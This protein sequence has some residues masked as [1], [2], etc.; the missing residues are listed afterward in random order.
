MQIIFILI[1]LLFSSSVLASTLPSPWSS[2]VK[3]AF[4]T[5]YN[6]SS[7]LWFTVGHGILTEVY[8]PTVD[9]AQL[10]DQQFL[11]TDGKSFLFEER[12]NAHTQVEW[13]EKGV[14]AFRIINKDPEGRFQ[15]E[16]VIFTDPNRDSLIQKIKITKYVPG[17]QFFLLHNPSAQNTPLGN[18]GFASLHDFP[19]MGLF[20][21]Q[22]NQAQAVAASVPFRKVSA[23]FYG[24]TDGY[25]DLV[26]DFHMDFEYKNADHG[27]VVLMG[28]LQLPEEVGVDT[29]DLVL[30]FSSNLESAYKTAQA[31]LYSDTNFIL[32]KYKKE[33]QQYQN[34]ILNLEPFSLDGGNLFRASVALL[35]SME[36][37]THPGGIIASPTIPWGEHVEDW[38]AGF[39]QG[40]SRKDLKAGYHLIWPRDLY[41]MAT[42]FLAIEDT[43]TAKAALDFL[44]NTQ[45]Q[46]QAGDWEY[47]FRKHSKE[48]SWFQNTW[49]SGEPFWGG[50]QLDQVALPIVLAYRLWKADEV[51]ASSVW[52]MVKK[53]ADFIQAFGPWTPMERWEEA[54]GA[55]PSTI[56][57]ELAGL[58]K[59]SEF[60]QSVGDFERAKRYQATAQ[61]WNSKEGD[62]LNTWTFTRSGS[63]QFGNYFIRIA[64]AGSWDEIWDP[65]GEYTFWIGNGGGRHR[66]KDILDGGFLELVRLGVRP[67][68]DPLIEESVLVYDQHIKVDLK[69]I[70]PGYYRYTGDQYNYDDTSGKQTHGMLWPLLTGE[71]GHYALGLGKP[72]DP[73]IAAMEKMATPSHMLPEQVWDGG[74]FQGMPTGAAT[75]LGWAHAEYIKLLR[76][77]A[78]QKI[79]GQ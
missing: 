17:L 35:K 28:W 11:V 67:A 14:P 2:G 25:Q 62:N 38:N 78:D 57:A 15:I 77:K 26:R 21:W 58:F 8:W 69:G 9:T 65:N 54:F 22:D 55:S 34:S 13:I 79:F 56:A 51:S 52:E 64:G 10:R 5:A 18:S 71:R 30:S 24:S 41:Q 39:A 29:F 76:S 49:L 72:V 4:G 37:K 60:A 7:K 12:K 70:G 46:S 61:A 23:G 20:A 59:A 63:F 33:W 42:A 32:N 53:A 75:P 68:Q 3:Q 66:E 43:K 48:G 73:Y 45:I 27:D 47:G 31:T 16:R 44:K 19:G 6:P 1:S 50:L 40:G 74:D 36:D